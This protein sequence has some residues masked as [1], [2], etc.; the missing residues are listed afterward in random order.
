MQYVNPYDAALLPAILGIV[1][2][3]KRMG[4]SSKWAPV[5]SVALGLVAGYF[6]IAPGQPLQAALSGISMGLAAVGLWSGPKN[7]VEGLR[8]R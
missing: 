7:T 6:Y 2:V 5:A 1:E 4:L 3:A 8:A